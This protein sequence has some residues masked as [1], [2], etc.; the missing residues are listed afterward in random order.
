MKRSV[1]TVLKEAFQLMWKDIKNT[2]WA[3]LVV[4]VYLWVNRT[5]FYSSCVMV[6]TTGFPCPGCGLTRAG[7]ALLRG[8]FK[9]AFQMHPFIY[10]IAALVFF[11]CLYRYILQRS[12]KVFVK[13]TIALIVAM[14]AFYVY[15]MIF[16]FPGEP[17]MSYYENNFIHTFL[18]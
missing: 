15:R 17:P 6:M 9:R 2:K 11:F 4:A 12:Q 10:A 14:L 1:K 18:M 13:W 8:D 7:F 16:V 5:F 3:I